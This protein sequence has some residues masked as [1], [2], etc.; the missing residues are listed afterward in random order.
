MSI[1][2]ISQTPGTNLSDLKEVAA[3]M[4]D[5]IRAENAGAR[6]AALEAANRRGVWQR[7]FPSQYERER[8][9]IG[10][11]GLRQ[12]SESRRELLEVY[13]AAQIEIARKSADALVA[14]Q[15][16]HLQ[17]QLAT[18]AS[19][20][21]S[22][23]NDTMNAARSK[24]LTDMEPQFAMIEKIGRPELQGPA[25]QSAL[26]QVDMYFNFNGKLLNGF[27]ESLN[28]RVGGIAR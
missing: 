6:Q 4:Q 3:G 25:Y 9:R 28:N 26:Q 24:F 10:I 22:E 27:I 2:P 21:I 18:F 15:G 14:A 5:Y 17:S 19:A 16:M 20:K 11:Q 7:L 12:L 23:L 1:Q 8:Q 13:T